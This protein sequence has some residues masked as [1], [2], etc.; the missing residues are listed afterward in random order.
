V[1]LPDLDGDGYLPP[2]IHAAR[3]ADIADLFGVSTAT[4]ARQIGLLRQV[5]E[6]AREYPTIKRILVWGSFVTN[7]AEPAD[8]D[9]SVVVS[10][11]HPRTRIA[12]AHR[13]FFVPVD[14]RR[15]YGVD[16]SFLVIPDYPLDYYSDKLDFVCHRRAGGEC[17][18]AEISLR[19]EFM[20]D[21]L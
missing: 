14:A 19:G 2:G 17:G 15:Y 8:V 12:R 5:V 9:Y 6:A 1:P 3:L 11:D 13:R 4:R 21:V 18:I 7:K 10:V 16:K 20:G